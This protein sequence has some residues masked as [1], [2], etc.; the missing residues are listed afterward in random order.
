MIRRSQPENTI[1]AGRAGHRAGA[2][3]WEFDVQLTADGVPILLHDAS[4][5]RT[6]DVAAKFGDDPRADLGY[7]AAE[8][9]LDEI[10]RLDAGSW[11]LDGQGGGRSARGFGTLD[12]IEPGM[13]AA[14]ADRDVRVPTLEQALELTA[15]LDWAANIEI[16]SAHDGDFSLL[17]AVLATI[18]RLGVADRVLISSFDH[19]E[20]A[21]AASRAPE[22]AT[23]VLVD[24]PLFRPAHYVRRTVGADA[25]HI[26][27]RALGAGGAPYRRDPSVGRLR[28][29]G[30]EECRKEGLP[31]LV[32]TVNERGPGKVAGHLAEAGVAGLFTDD[33]RAIVEH[34]TPASRRTR[35][36]SDDTGR[37]AAG[38]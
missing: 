7:L 17:D 6:T 23:G 30:L 37:L 34:F 18:H 8:F 24:A 10:W 21:R 22:V 14:I 36:R 13:R 32:Y 33:P 19:A 3:G 1:E 26:S 25:Y 35:P 20:V 2:D 4:L 15:R 11:F 29:S 38:P 9:R 12:R 5:L 28:A 16:K 27:T 31:V